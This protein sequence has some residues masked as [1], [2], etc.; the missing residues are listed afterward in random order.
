M[1][2]PHNIRVILAIE[3]SGPFCSVGLLGQDME[4]KARADA[5]FQHA[6]N[7]NE[8]LAML[9]QSVG[10]DSLDTVALSLGPGYF[11]SLRAGAAAAKA[12]ALVMDVKLVGVNTLECIGQDAHE[13]PVAC[14]L[15]AKKGQVYAGVYDHQG[16]ELLDV[17]IYEV[18]ELADRAK[19]LGVAGFAGR[20]AM[21]YQMGPLVG[22]ADPDP[23]T[24]AKMARDG[25]GVPLDPDEFE[26]MY[27]REPD[28][29]VN[30]RGK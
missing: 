5:P 27:I 18:E 14:A 12:F 23:I 17:G 25:K 1:A 30:L 8:L 3:T 26:P 6:E 11:T 28:A 9:Q 16:Q 15:D 22:P 21:R 29:V 7:L 10:F 24:L 19:E 2:L 4:F 13:Y 20:G